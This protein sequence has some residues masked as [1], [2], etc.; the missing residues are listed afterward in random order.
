MTQRARIVA[1]L[2]CGPHDGGLL[3][4]YFDAWQQLRVDAD[5]AVAP[6][7]VAEL[8][9]LS[10]IDDKSVDAIWASHCLEHLFLHQVPQA[11]SEF[12]R[13]LSDHGFAVILVPD[14]QTVASYFSADRPHEAVY[15][16][17][18]GPISAHDM[19]YGHGDAIAGGR[20]FMAHRCGF[21]PGLLQSLVRA[22]PFAEAIILRRQAR[23]E[24]VAVLRKTAPA[25]PA[26]RD[27]LMQALEL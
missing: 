7:I 25:S 4:D 21:T 27:A 5:K 16:S 13:V 2:G 11:L 8:T 9:D 6:D 12:H 10:S 3:P 14:L 22:T 15:Q 19:F 20:T 23:L 24:L 17:G 26:E 18:A 1:N